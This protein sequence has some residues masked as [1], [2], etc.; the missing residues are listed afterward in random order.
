MKKLLYILIAAVCA[1][2][3]C[4]KEMTL[5]EKLAGDW[6]CTAASIDAELYVSFAADK[7]FSLY[8]Q[9]GEGAFRVYNGTWSL[10]GSTLSGQYNDGTSWATSYEVVSTDEDT[11]TL[12]AEGISETYKRIS[13]GIPEE[14][15]AS[16]VTVVK[17]EGTDA[18]PF[19]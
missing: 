4:K 13:G 2:T 11:L 18:I 6:H 7:T 5:E 1:L 16:C 14:V 15:L 10:S 9:I 3:S 8:Q 19:L 12:T 17:S